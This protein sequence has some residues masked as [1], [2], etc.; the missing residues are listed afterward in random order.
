MTLSSPPKKIAL[1]SCDAVSSNHPDESLLLQALRAQGYE[2]SMPS[3]TSEQ[4]WSTFDYAIVRTTW[5]YALQSKKFLEVLRLMDSQTKLLNPFRLIE[6]NIHK[7]YLLELSARGVTIV[8]TLMIKDDEELIL[9]DEWNYSRYIVKPAISATAYK[10]F[11]V[12]HQELITD[13]FRTELH[14]GDW[15]IQPFIEGI[16]DGEISL[17]YFH[18]EFSHAVLKTPKAGDFRV[19]EEHGGS[20]R[21]MRVTP[22]LLKFGEQVCRSIPYPWLFARVDL[23]IYQGQ[24]LLMELEL[25]EPT[26]NFRMDPKASENFLKAFKLMAEKL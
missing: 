14:E 9:P 19:Q 16:K 13:S 17:H 21:P 10:T 23:V 2:V 5:D 15:L 22:E 4:D 24:Y 1:L 11:I 6:W 3:W 12:N 8:P 26:L 25:I 7:R 20:F 18:H